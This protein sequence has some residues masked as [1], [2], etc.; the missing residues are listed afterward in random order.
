[1]VEEK[2]EFIQIFIYLIDKMKS[3]QDAKNAL[4]INNLITELLQMEQ[5]KIKEKFG[6]F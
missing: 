4:M 6:L 1:M 2:Y 5:Y 3:K